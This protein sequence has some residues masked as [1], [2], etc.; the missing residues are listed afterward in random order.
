[1]SATT[2]N[3]VGPLEASLARATQTPPPQPV[4]SLQ[5]SGD[6]KDSRAEAKSLAAGKITVEHRA[7]QPTGKKDKDGNDILAPVQTCVIVHGLHDAWTWTD[8][9]NPDTGNPVLVFSTA[10]TDQEAADY[11][12]GRGAD[13]P[14]GQLAG[15]TEVLT[16]ANGA[17]RRQ[18][19]AIVASELVPHPTL[20]GVTSLHVEIAPSPDR[21]GTKMSNKRGH[22]LKAHLVGPAKSKVSPH[23]E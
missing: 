12:N 20:D 14:H 19:V 23:V 13:H 17:T 22:E 6:A 7:G 8:H 15:M 11:F 16:D 9:F 3:E 5:T 10:P 4:P 18:K 21:L 2:T 1:M